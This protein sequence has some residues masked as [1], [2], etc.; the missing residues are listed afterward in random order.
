MVFTCGKGCEMDWLPRIV[1]A[2]SLVS[3]NGRAYLME[4]V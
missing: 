2:E 1:D 3:D 4:V